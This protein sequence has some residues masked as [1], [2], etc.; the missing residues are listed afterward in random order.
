LKPDILRPLLACGD[1]G[2]CWPWPKPAR[3]W[4]AA[5]CLGS[6]EWSSSV[7]S[8]SSTLGPAAPGDRS[9]SL[10]HAITRN[11]QPIYSRLALVMIAEADQREEGQKKQR[12]KHRFRSGFR[13]WR[14]RSERR[15]C[16]ATGAAN[17]AWARLCG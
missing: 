2:L 12:R 10:K 4:K 6:G 16:V 15:P 14:Q 3:L 5:G 7:T 1:R 8:P 13:T 17:N 9:A 11:N